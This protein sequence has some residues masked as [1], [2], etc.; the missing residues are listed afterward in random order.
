MRLAFTLMH[1][2]AGLAIAV[3][4]FVS[5]ATG[6]IISWD[7]ALD[8]WLNPHLAFVSS[9]GTPISSLELARQIEQRHPQVT[10]RS[11]PMLAEDGE[12]LAFGVTPRINPETNLAYVPGYNQVFVDPITGVELGKR[13]AGVAWPVTRENLMSF[14][15]VLHFT[16]H[17][18]EFWGINRWGVW[19]MGAVA[20]V[21]LIDCFVGFYLTLPV[22]KAARATRAPMVERQLSKGFWDRW[23][24]AWKIKTTGSAYRINFDIHRAF[25]LW[26]WSLLFILA[27]TAVTLNFYREIAQPVVKLFSSFT[28]TPF[29]TRKPTGKHDVIVPKISF[30]QVLDIGRAE[31]AKRGWQE[32]VGSMFYANRYGVY[33]VRFFNAGDDHGAAGVGPPQLYFDGQDGRYLGDRVPWVGTA[34][35]IFLQV[36]FPLHSGRILGM[37]G[38]ILSSLMGI[39][40]ATLSVTGVVI[41]WRK[42]RARVAAR[43]KG[44][45]AQDRALMPAE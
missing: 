16:L 25:G 12:S 26:V 33:G 1:R 35:D 41:W 39:V 22:R 2:W 18:P 20:V 27:L 4:L 38:R 24:P 44:A 15:Y 29:D 10:V 32:P 5:G 11:V 30:A 19:F 6:A 36:Q 31:A 21:W 37:P 43:A 34:G 23:K 7:H 45:F 3:F 14:L 42:R 40:V 28:P 8:E 13:A 9:R 17:I